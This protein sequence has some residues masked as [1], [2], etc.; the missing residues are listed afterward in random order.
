MHDPA[1]I[2]PILP[3]AGPSGGQVDVQDQQD[4]ERS[5]QEAVDPERGR[6]RENPKRHCLD[7]PGSGDPESRGEKEERHSGKDPRN[8][9]AESAGA[10]HA[11][12]V[13]R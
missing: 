8:P 3:S 9:P 2:E 11:V 6:L 7:D 4:Q 12:T 10:D 13:P 1:L 5:P